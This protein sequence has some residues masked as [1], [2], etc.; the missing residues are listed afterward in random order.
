MS[1]GWRLVL[2]VAVIMGGVVACATPPQPFD[3][4]NDRNEKPGPGLFSGDKGGFVI[5]GES[6]DAP[7]EDEAAPVDS[8]GVK[9]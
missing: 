7:A 8:D 3:Y 4:H 6:A 2:A 9:K 1:R 5:I